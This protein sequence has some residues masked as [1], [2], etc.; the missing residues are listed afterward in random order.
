MP[1]ALATPIDFRRARRPAPP[2]STATDLLRCVGLSALATSETDSVPV[3]LR[4]VSPDTALL[5]E[6]QPMEWLHVVAAGSFKTVQVDAEGYEQVIGFAIRGDVVGLDGLGTARHASSAIALE[7]ST[8]MGLAFDE[9]VR[10]GRQQPVFELLLH[11]AAGAELQ[12]R[13]S[14]QY[15]MSAPSSEVRVARFLLHFARRL[16]ALDHPAQPMRLCMTRR[17]IASHLGIAHETVSRALSSLAQAGCLHVANRSIEILDAG[18]LEDLQRITRGAPRGRPS[19][20]RL[21]RVA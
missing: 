13:A 12:S 20:E 7:S 17:D 1:A 4:D 10:L 9:L 2:R 16:H 8:V 11:R 6:G 18:A 15:L 21:A 19:R 5:H 3:T 14:T